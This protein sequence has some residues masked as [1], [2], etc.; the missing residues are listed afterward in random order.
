[1]SGRCTGHYNVNEVVEVVSRCPE[2]HSLV[3][4][5]VTHKVTAE[6]T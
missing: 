6:M 3:V 2:H 1:M 4:M 5:A